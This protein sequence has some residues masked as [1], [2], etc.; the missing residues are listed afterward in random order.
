[1]PGNVHDSQVFSG[2]FEK[3][4]DQYPKIE[5]AVAGYKQPAICRERADYAV[6]TTD[7][8]QRLFPE[9]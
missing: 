9:I 1:M 6:Q 5:A 3:P 4:N 7:D 8:P 2:V